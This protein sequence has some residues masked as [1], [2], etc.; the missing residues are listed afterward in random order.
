MAW[1]RSTVIMPGDRVRLSIDSA[2]VQ[3]LAQQLGLG[4]LD[5]TTLWTAIL[6]S[7]LVQ[8]TLHP[9]GGQLE[10]WVPGQPLPDDWPPDDTDAAN[11]Y[12]ADFLYSGSQGL[13]VSAGHV[14]T[15]LSVWVGKG[16]G[17]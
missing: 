3:A 2:G 7:P 10:A 12:H 14:P 11:E 8:Q 17:A 9:Q 5:P 16:L 4:A 6:Q 15:N 13:D 1:V